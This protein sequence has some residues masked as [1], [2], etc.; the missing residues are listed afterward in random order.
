MPLPQRGEFLKRGPKLRKSEWCIPTLTGI[1][2]KMRDRTVRVICIYTF[3]YF[4]EDDDTDNTSLEYIPAP[5]S[6][7]GKRSAVTEPGEDEDPLDAF[8]AGIEKQ[9]MFDICMCVWSF[10]FY[11]V[12]IRYQCKVLRT[13]LL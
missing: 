10:T 8:M 3:R 7:T 9:V 6:P 2:T 11:Y 4:E 12:G 5:G 1:A 13:C